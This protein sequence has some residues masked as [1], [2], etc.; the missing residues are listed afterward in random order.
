MF[1]L[2]RSISYSTN[3]PAY[4]RNIIW[5]F[6]FTVRDYSMGYKKI[7]FHTKRPLSS[8][9]KTAMLQQQVQ[10][11]FGIYIDIYI[12]SHP[13]GAIL[14]LYICWV[15][16]MPNILKNVGPSGWFS[17]IFYG[18]C[19]LYTENFAPSGRFYIYA[20]LYIY[21]MPNLLKKIAPSERYY[22]YAKLYICR[23][24]AVSEFM[25][26]RNH[27]QNAKNEFRVLDLFFSLVS[28]SPH[29]S[30]GRSAAL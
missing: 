6:L 1:L 13:F 25:R 23:I 7:I 21:I 22:I 9:L 18:F 11:W 20:E 17:I 19:Y 2:D 27:F 12:L 30:R 26:T 24:T 15:I 3:E 10:R 29:G 8:R 16:Y 28:T 5:E 4:E 14:S